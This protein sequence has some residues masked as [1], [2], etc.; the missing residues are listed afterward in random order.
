MAS[1]KRTRNILLTS[2]VTAAVLGLGASLAFAAAGGSAH[3][4]DSAT[5]WTISPG[6]SAKAVAGKVSITDTNTGTVITCTSASGAGVLKSGS[7]LSGTEIGEATEPPI[8][9]HCYWIGLPWIW[10]W[11]PGPWWL[12]AISYNS[13][14][15]IT[16]GDITGLNVTGT[17]DGCT[18]V[19]DGT[20]ATSDNGQVRGT[21]SNA[22]GKGTFLSTG[23]NLH[24][25]DVSGCDGAFNNGDSAVAKGSFT[26]SPKQT[27]TGS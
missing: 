8:F 11:P 10:H 13:A 25:Y 7:G 12:N 24:F 14:K 26:V 21:Y 19:L 20:S 18:I 1:L 22:T 23:G 4:L 27:A 6:G 17:S 5:T 16:T 2:A 9:N 15:G 3:H